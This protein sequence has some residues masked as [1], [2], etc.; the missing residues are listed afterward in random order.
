MLVRPVVVENKDAP[1]PTITDT[2]GA[3]GHHSRYIRTIRVTIKAVHKY[4]L[5]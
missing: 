3:T 1:R 4:T 5:V 2:T